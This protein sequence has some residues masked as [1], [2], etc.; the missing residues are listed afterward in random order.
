MAL[1]TKGYDMAAKL[2]NDLHAFK[3]GAKC[4]QGYRPV[5]TADL[6]V[7]Q[8]W[9]FGVDGE[10][11][12]MPDLSDFRVSVMYRTFAG[13]AKLFNM[14]L[15]ATIKHIPHAYEAVIV[16]VEA[17]KELFEEVIEPHRD[18]APF[19]IRIV[20]E[21]ALLD[22]PVQQKYSKVR[23]VDDENMRRSCTAE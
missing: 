12:T 1:S 4:E 6:S 18:A 13:D 14:S 19:P 21:P 2:A 16:V 10:L 5:S 9:E 22:G 23:F 7:K 3:L 15:A 20:T 17:D 8:H 11:Q